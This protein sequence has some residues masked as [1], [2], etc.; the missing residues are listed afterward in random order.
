[1]CAVDLRPVS[2]VEGSGFRHFCRNLNASYK[3]PGR[4][5]VTK[6]VTAMYE[7]AKAE[8][9]EE[10]KGQLISLTSDLWSSNVMQGYITLTCHFVNESWQL[11][12][13]VI[14]TREMAERHTGVNIAKT[15]TALTQ[16]FSI[17]EVC[18]T[19]LLPAYVIFFYFSLFSGRWCLW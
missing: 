6:Y 1:M 8:V 14:A 12:S 15:C 17:E 5:T 9:I 4:T 16:E 10:V 3:V 19:C 18:F 7:S 11:K 2:M 13:L